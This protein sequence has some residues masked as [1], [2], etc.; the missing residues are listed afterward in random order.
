MRCIRSCGQHHAITSLDAI[1]AFPNRF[2]NPRTLAPHRRWKLRLARASL[3]IEL[4]PDQFAAPF[5]HIQKIDTRRRD[6]HQNLS[7]A[8]H[9]SG[10]FFQPHHLRPA[11]FIY[12]DSA[13]ELRL[14]G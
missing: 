14:Q 11:I 13:H 2:H 10:Q 4:L 8:R 9:R 1:D 3:L 6:A 12:A 7:S 5:L